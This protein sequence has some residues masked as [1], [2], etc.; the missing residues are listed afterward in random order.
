MLRDIHF[1]IIGDILLT[2]GLIGYF[3]NNPLLALL[4]FIVAGVFF[5][6]QL[7]KMY[8]SKPKNDTD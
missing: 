6:R 3:M 7:I 5:I 2:V 1:L 4:S 8:V